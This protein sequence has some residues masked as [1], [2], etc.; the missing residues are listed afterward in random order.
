MY[1][2]NIMCIFSQADL[3]RPDLSQHQSARCGMFSFGNAMTASLVM[4]FKVLCYLSSSSHLNLM[5]ASD[6]KSRNVTGIG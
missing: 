2:M 5:V 4:H 6:L 1:K 3:S